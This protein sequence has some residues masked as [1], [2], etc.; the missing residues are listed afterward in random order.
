MNPVISVIVPSHRTSNE[1]TTIL[2]DFK[3]QTFK[4]FELIVVYDG[5]PP[6]DVLDLMK[7]HKD[8][9]FFSIEKDPGNMSIAPGTRPRNYGVQQARGEYCVFC[10]DD[11]RYKDTYLEALITGTGN[12]VINIVQMSC[13]ES[14]M[15]RNG[16]STRIRLIPEIGLPG[17]PIICHVG[18]PCFIVRTEWA[19]QE[20]WRE[21]KEH[22]FHFIRR[23]CERFRPQVRIVGGMNVDVDGL[24]TQGMKDWVS[25]PPFYRE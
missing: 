7:S 2:R 3:N 9:R 21:E 15:F 22:D 11:D 18:T 17:F 25:I 10:D 12:G 4:Q 14:R 13:A 20:P 6:Q 16:D 19:L 8:I 24:V 5:T 23:I 1:L